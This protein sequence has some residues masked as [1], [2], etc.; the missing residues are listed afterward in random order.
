M[1]NLHFT[2]VMLGCAM[3]VSSAIARPLK[4][5]MSGSD[6]KK[7]QM[8]LTLVRDRNGG[9]A[10]LPVNG[11]FGPSTKKATLRFQ[12]MQGIYANGIVGGATINKA[13]EFG[14][15]SV[16]VPGSGRPSRN[17]TSRVGGS[18]SGDLVVK[19]ISSDGAWATG[20]ITNNTG[21][22]YR[23]VTVYVRISD[24]SGNSF[25]EVT[26]SKQSLGPYESWRFRV[27]NNSGG[28]ASF[29]I[30]RIAFAGRS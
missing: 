20:T 8:F 27:L 9:D 10:G 3:A 28:T 13:K 26:D 2:L 22:T 24:L 25:G 15:D 30:T 21:Y 6:V 7:W 23:S 12:K 11:K 4:R 29:K 17:S 1:K 14:Y 19:D 5:G 18:A 16:V